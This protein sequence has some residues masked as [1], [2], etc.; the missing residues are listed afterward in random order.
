MSI[1]RLSVVGLIALLAWTPL[2]SA[3][4]AVSHE[5]VTTSPNAA[6]SFSAST[7]T[8]GAAVV[9]ACR[10]SVEG[11]PIRYWTDGGTPTSTGGHLI[12]VGAQFILS[13][14][15]AKRFS[16][17]AT[18]SAGALQATCY[19]GDQAP[20]AAADSGMA[21]QNVAGTVMPGHLLVG[22]DPSGIL[23]ALTVTSFGEL[24]TRSSPGLP[25]PLCNPVR[26]TNC[27]PKGF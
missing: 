5:T 25:L 15:E 16:V 2:A 13:G 3:Q 12:N 9:T 24:A 14:G 26:S 8:V 21:V 19:L 20:T 7:T 1:T 18:T 4:S 22:L 23:R 27:Q 6:V 10:V 17:I 11:S